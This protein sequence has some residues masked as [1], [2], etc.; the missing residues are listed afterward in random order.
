MRFGKRNYSHST[1]CSV[2][3][4]CADLGSAAAQD[5][6]ASGAAG[7]RVVPLQIAAEA[8]A[9]GRVARVVPAA[10]PAHVHRVG[11]RGRRARGLR[12]V[13]L[14]GAVPAPAD[15]ARAGH[16]VGDGALVQ[17][18]GPDQGGVGVAG[19]DAPP[20]AALKVVVGE[21]MR[22]WACGAF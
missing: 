21:R 11:V 9:S 2:P 15:P 20:A 19:L 10:V 1:V 17:R 7:E 16:P 13:A 5:V 3:A 14:V 22:L 18:R 6:V 12:G 4:Y 8:A